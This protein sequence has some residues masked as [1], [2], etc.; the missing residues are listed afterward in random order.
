V[1]W[2]QFAPSTGIEA[3]FATAP[4]GRPDSIVAIVDFMA[5]NPGR[6]GMFERIGYVRYTDTPIHAH[7][8]GLLLPMI[9]PAKLDGAISALPRD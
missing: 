3:M 9:L 6:V 5:T 8:V 2:A 7:G 1:L 4:Q